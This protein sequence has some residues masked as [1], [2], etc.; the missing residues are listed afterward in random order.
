MRK[1]TRQWIS[2]MTCSLTTT[3]AVFQ[4]WDSQAVFH[5]AVLVHEIVLQYIIAGD[6]E[7]ETRAE[8]AGVCTWGSETRER[9]REVQHRPRPHPVER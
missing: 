4:Q 2:S 9:N 1:N 3:E 7:D 8:P 5:R 6:P